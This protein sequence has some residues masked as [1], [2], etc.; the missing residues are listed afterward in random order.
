MKERIENGVTQDRTRDLSYCRQMCWP[1]D[2]I[3]IEK[4]LAKILIGQCSWYLLQNLKIFTE[5]FQ[6]FW[7]SNWK[8]SELSR[9]LNM[10][11]WQFNLYSCIL[12]RI[13]FPS[14]HLRALPRNFQFCT[15][16]SAYLP[17]CWVAQQLPCQRN[18]V[19]KSLCKNTNFLIY[20]KCL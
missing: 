4:N 2:Q 8:N 13:F 9:V 1:L 17:I 12:Y 19:S 11:P 16:F 18:Q 7:L 20:A 5:F 6:F 3:L 10:R 14:L 15:I